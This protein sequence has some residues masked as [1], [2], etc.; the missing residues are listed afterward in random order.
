MKK[1]SKFLTGAA[2]A[3]LMATQSAVA[4]PLQIVGTPQEVSGPFQHNLFHLNNDGGTSGV[5][6]AWVGLDAD[7][8]SYYDPDTGDIQLSL[9]LYSDSSLTTETGTVTGS[10]SVPAAN[11]TGTDSGATAGSITFDFSD[12]TPSTTIDYS[13]NTFATSTDG[14]TANSWD[15]TYLTLWGA[16]LLGNAEVFDGIAA[17]S[18]AQQFLGSDLVFETG[19]PVPGTVPEPSTVILLGAGALGLALRRSRQA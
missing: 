15:G 12:G 1:L 10:G 9:V 19:E 8:L 14:F 6:T 7:A 18:A 5:I 13:D 3:C 17:F 16:G 11:L 4:V 2:V